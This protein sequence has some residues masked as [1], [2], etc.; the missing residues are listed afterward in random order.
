MINLT[1]WSDFAC[2]YC[3]IG[4]KR[5]M[6]VIDELDLKDKV[7]FNYRAYQ[8]DPNAPK[9]PDTST[10]ERMATKYGISLDEAISQ[11]ETI[12]KLGQELGLTFNYMDSRFC[13]TFDAHRLM[14]LAEDKYDAKVVNRLNFALFSAYFDA[15]RVL[16]DA[17]TLTD[18]AVGAGIKERHVKEVLDSNK[19]ADQVRYDEQEA[20]TIGVRGVPFFVINGNFAVPGAISES[21]WKE[22]LQ[23]AEKASASQ[24][25]KEKAH[26]CGPD[27]CEI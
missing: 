7:T 25:K 21:D 14:K 26:V 2:P 9:V 19:Y 3:Y 13:N 8:L 11:V 12:S 18:I 20:Q 1:I 23:N 15:S 4:E 17:A 27:G 6:N 5:L 24:P 22:V 10:P 16:S